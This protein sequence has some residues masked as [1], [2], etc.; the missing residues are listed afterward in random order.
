MKM[1]LEHI[2]VSDIQEWSKNN[3]GETTLAKR[4]RVLKIG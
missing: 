4:R 1:A 2:K 3:I